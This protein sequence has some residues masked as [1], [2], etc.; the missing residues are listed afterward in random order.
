MSVKMLGRD[1]VDAVCN[2]LS[3]D[4]QEVFGVCIKADCASVVTVELQMHATKLESDRIASALMRDAVNV[5][6]VG[7]KSYAEIERDPFGNVMALHPISADRVSPHNKDGYAWKVKIDSDRFILFRADEVIEYAGPVV[8]NPEK[9]TLNVAPLVAQC[10]VTP[11]FA[12]AFCE[13]WRSVNV[14]TIEILNPGLEYRQIET[15]TAGTITPVN[16]DPQPDFVEKQK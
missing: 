8:P 6:Y 2:M 3:I 15:M 16:D 5:E 9:V 13:E 1:F 4:K 7:S 14:P 11:G 10:H 12:E